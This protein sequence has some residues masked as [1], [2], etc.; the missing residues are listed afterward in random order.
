MNKKK[1]KK[2]ITINDKKAFVKEILYEPYLE[3]EKNCVYFG[4]MCNIDEHGTTPL[5]VVITDDE[6]TFYWWHVWS[7]DV[8]KFGEK[9][10][11]YLL[12][13]TNGFFRD[14]YIHV[15]VGCVNN[16]MIRI[17]IDF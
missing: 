13:F 12:G 17:K 2:V 9:M 1:K 7:R 3:I 14:A 4:K 10:R 11:N 5:E 6:I 8:E 16:G 15:V